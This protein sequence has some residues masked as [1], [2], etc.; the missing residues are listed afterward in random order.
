M[1]GT[2]AP[3][4]R[5]T[6]ITHAFQVVSGPVEDH[7]HVCSSEG[8]GLRTPPVCNIREREKKIRTI[9]MYDLRTGFE[10]HLYATSEIQI[11]TPYECIIPRRTSS[12]T[13]THT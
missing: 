6:S 7:L 11:Y 4:E 3:D 8:E 2:K 1:G 12:T 13:C 9:C 10:H 5:G